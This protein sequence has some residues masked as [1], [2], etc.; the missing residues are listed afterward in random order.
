MAYSF[1]AKKVL[2]L[3]MVFQKSHKNLI[4]NETKYGCI[5]N[6]TKYGWIKRVNCTIDN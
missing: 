6:H 1:K 2:Q 5:E 3:V 4:E